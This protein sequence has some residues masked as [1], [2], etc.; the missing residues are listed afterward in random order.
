M[1]VSNVEILDV[2][3]FIA[4]GVAGVVGWIVGRR[5]Q[6]NDFLGELQSSI[7]MLA[8]KNKEQMQEILNL[9]SEIIKLQDENSLI[10]RDQIDEIIKLK[11]DMIKLQDENSQLRKEVDSLKTQLGNIKKNQKTDETK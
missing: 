11:G 7:D 3:N 1:T 10:R 8:E 4:T 6:K 2:I 5:K 9:R